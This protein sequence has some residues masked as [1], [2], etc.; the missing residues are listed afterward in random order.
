[1]N[2]EPFVPRNRPTLSW[3]TLSC[4][5]HLKVRQSH[6][7]EGL[8]PPPG[9]SGESYVIPPRKLPCW[10]SFVTWTHS[11][12]LASLSV[13]QIYMQARKLTEV[14]LLFW[15]TGGAS[16]HSILSWVCCQTEFCP[17]FCLGFR[18]LA[19]NKLGFHL[20]PVQI[21]YCL[22]FLPELKIDS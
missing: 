8:T 1:M 3:S 21:W 14:L 20:K 11:P 12:A 6:H 19:L 10:L 22:R 7:L 15:W 18:G 16:C 13:I 2:L 9:S 4:L 17:D 5:W